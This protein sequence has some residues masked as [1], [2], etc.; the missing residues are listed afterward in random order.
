[1]GAKTTGEYDR[2]AADRFAHR[3]RAQPCDRHRVLLHCHPN[4]R[5]VYMLKEYTIDSA[6][7]SCS[8]VGQ[9]KKTV[10]K[11]SARMGFF[12]FNA[13]GQEKLSVQAAGN[14]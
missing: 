10:S 5:L 9:F 8:I 7:H 11:S 2:Q 4:N 1:M 14:D 13:A 12:F 3:S 6:L